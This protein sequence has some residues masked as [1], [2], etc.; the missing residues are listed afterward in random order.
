MADIDMEE[1]DSPIVDIPVKESVSSIDDSPITETLEEIQKDYRFFA[2]YTYHANSISVIATDLPAENETSLRSAIA[3][4]LSKGTV[5]GGSGNV[6]SIEIGLSGD[7]SYCYYCLLRQAGEDKLTIEGASNNLITE[8]A[9]SVTSR[10]YL[11]LFFLTIFTYRPELDIFSHGLL[12]LIDTDL[13]EISKMHSYLV[14]WYTSSMEF[15]CRS[16]QKLQ[17][18]VAYV[19]HAAMMN[20]KIDIHGENQSLKEDIEK[21]SN[22][23]SLAGLLQHSDISETQLSPD[24]PIDTSLVEISR[25]PHKEKSLGK[26]SIVV[27]PDKVT[28]DCTEC[29]IFCR[30]WAQALCNGD[31]HNP[32]Y[33]RQIIE[34]YKLKAIQDMNTLQRL[35]RQAENDHYALYR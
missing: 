17:N 5:Y 32:V 14:D 18:N 25:K 4:R 2:L 24:T 9:A 1:I 3:K 31:D 33:L 22:C 30:D 20:F 21:F 34:N 19:I 6:A 10:E 7:S 12:P 29:N 11:S 8:G 16:V 15:L 27:T 26:L 35:I 13:T 28:F 23:C